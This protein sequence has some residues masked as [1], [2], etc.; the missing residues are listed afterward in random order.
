MDFTMTRVLA[1]MRV[2][3]FRSVFAYNGLWKLL[4]DKQKYFVMR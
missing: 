4:I 2:L 3:A 1:E